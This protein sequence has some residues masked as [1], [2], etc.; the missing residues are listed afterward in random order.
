[1]NSSWQIK[2]K[3]SLLFSATKGQHY[4]MEKPKPYMNTVYKKKW[5]RKPF[6]VLKEP[7]SYP[8][9]AQLLSHT[10]LPPRHHFSSVFR[11]AV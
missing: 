1:M 11:L 10:P 2:S 7:F 9:P 6:I 5:D 4:K 8:S 3:S